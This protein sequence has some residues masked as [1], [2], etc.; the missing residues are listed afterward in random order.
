[1]YVFSNAFIK[2]NHIK[3]SF[4]ISLTLT[5]AVISACFLFNIFQTI[6]KTP[7]QPN[8]ASG[9]V[10]G[11]NEITAIYRDWVY[12][13]SGAQASGGS[14]PMKLF[15]EN[16]DPKNGINGNPVTD[17]LPFKGLDLFYPA[18]K[19][20]QVVIDLQTN[21]NLTDIYLHERGFESDSVWVYTG[22]MQNWQL[23]LALKTTGNS[24]KWGWKN[25]QLNVSSRLV[26]IRFN[27]FKSTITEMVLYGKPVNGK[28]PAAPLPV[29]TNA[30]LYRSKVT[31]RE[32]AG[33]NSYDWVAAKFMQPFY[34]TR[35]YL[36]NSWFDDAP[37]NAY[38]N[39][40]QYKFNNFNL[41]YYMQ[42][43]GFA[44]SLK[45]N[46]SYLW[47]CIKGAPGYIEKA[48]LSSHHPPVT[49]IGMA[50][51]N[52][53]SYG[54]HSNLF[55][56]LAAAFGSKKIDTSLLQ[57]N[58]VPKF[59]GANLMHVFENGNEQDASWVKDY[60]LPATYFAVSSADYDGHE[61]KLGARHGIKN[62]DATSKLM[63]AGFIG[64]DT[65]RTRTLKFL[66]EQLRSDKKFIWEAGIQYHYYSNDGSFTHAATKGLTPEEDGLR[67]KLAY[68]KQWHQKLLP[69]IA[70]ILGETGYDRN[71]QS[72]QSTPLLK[73]LNEATSQG[74]MTIRSMMSAFMSG[75]DRYNY[76]MIRNATNEENPAGTFGTSGMISGPSGGAGTVYPVWYYCRNVINRLANY[77]PDKVIAET[78]N[79]WIYKLRHKQQKDLVVYYLVSPTKNGSIIKNYQLQLPSIKSTSVSK[80]N[81]FHEEAQQK[82][83]EIFNASKKYIELEISEIPTILFVKEND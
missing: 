82:K 32:F 28:Y 11:T 36:N 17:P 40:I 52:P 20:Y 48:G 49:K 69:G 64:L 2:K 46:N 7:L 41:P 37:A 15:D 27:T 8:V 57:F 24:T 21:Y 54:R 1:M 60:W 71:Q 58:D 13:L 23:Q 34:H 55:W 50:I 45:T 63:V 56:N 3:T 79:V 38:P 4:I 73:G 10:A 74:V 59:S 76:F 72:W 80:L 81:W 43:K 62:A 51:D 44:D 12:D 16:C 47:P 18:G 78:G 29:D 70:L 65:N 39:S 22:N 30:S 5:T 9:A 6:N 75:F 61:K 83:D 31:F 67:K 42:V 33:I 25:K 68:I 14:D 53:L 77:Y 35:L 66:C 26:M 19:G